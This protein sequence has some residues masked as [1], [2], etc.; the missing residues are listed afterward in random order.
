MSLLGKGI[1]KLSELEIDADKNWQAKGI[2]NLKELA[3]GMARGD[4]VIRGHSVLTRLPAGPVDYILASTGTGDIPQWIPV[5]G[6]LEIFLPKMILADMDLSVIPIDKVISETSLA[7]DTVI[8]TTDI[9]TQAISMEIAENLSVITIDNSISEES[10]TGTGLGFEIW[11]DVDG[12]VAED[13]GGRTDETAEATNDTP[14]NMT[15]LPAPVKVDDAYYFGFDDEFDLVRLRQDT[16][17][18]GVWSTIWEY[19]NGSS[20]AGLANVDDPTDGFR[21]ASTGLFDITWD[22]PGDWEKKDIEG[23]ELYWVRSRVDAF[24]SHTTQ[25]KGTRV[26]VLVAEGNI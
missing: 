9:P 12:A 2:S 16:P 7:V 19:W 26:R 17:G 21:P 6:P 1:R 25:P 11:Q 20:W 23:M 15:L 22:I 4:L 10:V 8:E 3:P 5:P 13:G 18:A 14:N 24:T